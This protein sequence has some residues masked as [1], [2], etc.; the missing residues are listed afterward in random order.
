LGYL[1]VSYS[2]LSGQLGKMEMDKDVMATRKRSLSPHQ[3]QMRFMTC[4]FGTLMVL[5]AAAL[6]WFFNTLGQGA[7]HP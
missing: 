7:H 3:K 5:T 6:I 1:W 2:E 4:L